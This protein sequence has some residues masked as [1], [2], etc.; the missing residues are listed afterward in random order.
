MKIPFAAAMLL[1]IAVAEPAAAQI[2][3][4]V[5]A[6]PTFT[7]GAVAEIDEALTFGDAGL[8]LQLDGGIALGMARGAVDVRIFGTYA[9]AGR[10]F[11]AFNRDLAA[12][13]VDLELSG[14]VRV[15]G[16]GIGAAYYFATELASDLYP[17]VL[18]TGGVYQQRHTI[19][20]TGADVQPGTDSDV[21]RSTRIGAGG[22]LGLIWAPGR[23]RF[24]VEARLQAL[25]SAGESPG[26][27]IP[28]QLGVKL[29]RP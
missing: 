9:T 4:F 18:A 25:M 29:G 20:Y 6:G 15:I 21:E 19:D 5:A 8:G 12:G 16:A 22:G 10:D 24:F 26:Y 17:Y 28:V 13:G 11:D 2:Q 27:L 14:D 3:P 7:G 23:V 1:I